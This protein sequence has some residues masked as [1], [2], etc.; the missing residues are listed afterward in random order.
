MRV[1]DGHGEWPYGYTKPPLG[2][3]IDT[4]HPFLNGMQ[5]GWSLQEGFGREIRPFVGVNRGVLQTAPVWDG[6]FC[7][8][9]LSFNGLTDGVNMDVGT[10][11]SNTQDHSFTCWVK[12]RVI[13][14]TIQTLICNGG[15]GTSTGTSLAMASNGAIKFLGNGTNVTTIGNALVKVDEWH[16]VAVV[17]IGGATS[18]QRF[19]MDGRFDVQTTMVTSWSAGTNFVRLGNI[20]SVGFFNGWIDRPTIH[21]RQLTGEEIMNDYLAPWR[22]FRSPIATYGSAIV[23]A[24]TFQYPQ[25]E[26]HSYRGVLRGAVTG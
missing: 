16:H 19:Y 11:F 26:R 23:A 17:F 15:S 1:R 24:P 10:G 6:G 4:S 12:M 3:F 13:S 8:S 21:S 7:G 9:C 5:Y 2:S 20:N 18:T 25:L 14:G 22:F